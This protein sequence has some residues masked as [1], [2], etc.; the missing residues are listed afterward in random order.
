MK[1]KLTKIAFL[2]YL[3]LTN[4]ILFAKDDGGDVLGDGIIENNPGT[5]GGP[6]DGTDPQ[7]PI[8][9][10]LIWLLILG[11]AFAYYIY[12]TKKIKA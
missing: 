4:F 9:T 8:N 11:I 2:A 5:G 7:A 10:Q 3:L 12:K 1:A 6:N